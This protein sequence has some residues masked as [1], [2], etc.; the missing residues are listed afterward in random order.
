VHARS[1][2]DRDAELIGRECDGHV[3]ALERWFG[4]E[5]PERI[6]V[7]VF[8]SPEQKGRLMGAAT[9]YIAKPWRREIYIQMNRFPHPV[10][11]HELA[12]VIAGAAGQGPFR[13]AGP[14]F[15]IVPDPGRIE[16]VATAASPGDDDD[17]TLE[18]SAK[19]LL[20]LELLPPLERVFRL[21]FL[22]ESSAKAYTV[23]GAFVHWLH[24]TRGASA[25]RRWYGGESLEQ[26]T[27][28]GLAELE[29]EWRE[30]LAG[31][32]VPKEALESARARFDRPAIFDRSCPHVVDRLVEEAGTS[33]AKNDWRGASEAFDEA[34]RLDP[35]HVWAGIGAGTC[36]ARAGRYDEARVKWERV[37][38]DPAL[39]VVLKL[40]GT[41]AIAD[42]DL[43]LGL[44]RPARERYRL[45]AQQ[46]FDDD[47]LRALEVKGA[48][49]EP[50]GRDAI[51]ALLIGD[52]RL[53]RD[54]SIATAR[55][56]RWA[57]ER[58]TEGEPE[59]LLGRNFYQQGRYEDAAAHLDRALE[60]TLESSRLRREALRTRLIVAAA[61]GERGAAER[62]LARWLAEPGIR[63]A[64]REGMLRF[65]ERSGIAAPGSGEAR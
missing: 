38:S 37:A 9:T 59:Y 34:L 39:P 56:A 45:I 26:A 7:F 48:E 52:P 36:A 28:K 12:H 63:R 55:L 44:D 25:I 15:G 58:P 10:L 29:R 60:R 3:R 54:F 40:T 53:G 19:T 21:S 65:A 41:E 30:H 46:V 20:E 22:G 31:V 2:L 17:L 14:L 5:H 4:L 42:L 43:A 8:E 51:V 57:A 11:G 64:Q 35:H 50:L 16:G 13:V 6:T 62:V 18:Q 23:A 61:L 32:E 33:L 1:I 24:A 27:G 47:H 49:R